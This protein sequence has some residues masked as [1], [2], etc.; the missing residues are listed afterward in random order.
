M[1]SGTSL[2]TCDVP[3]VRGAAWCFSRDTDWPGDPGLMALSRTIVQGAALGWGAYWVM[4]R[5][6]VAGPSSDTPVL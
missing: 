2:G 4:Y 1:L 5:A 6:L 3:S